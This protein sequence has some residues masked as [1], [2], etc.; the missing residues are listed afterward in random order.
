MM[1]DRMISVYS[2]ANCSVVQTSNAFLVQTASSL[3]DALKRSEVNYDDND[4]TVNLPS[5][6]KKWCIVNDQ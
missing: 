1:A 3:N 2:N 6:D 4:T 5:H